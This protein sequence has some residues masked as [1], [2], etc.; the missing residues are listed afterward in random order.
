MKI[1]FFEVAPW[2]VSTLKK[3]F[4]HSLLVKESLNKDNVRAYKNLEVISTFIYSHLNKEVLGEMRL[5]FIATRSTG[6]NHIDTDFCK[7]HNILVSNVPEYGSTTVAEHTFGLILMLTRKLCLAE[8]HARK[9]N[10]DHFKLMGTDLYGKTIGIVGLG[11]IGKCVLKIAQGFG[12]KVVAFTHKRHYV[13]E[14][15]LNYQYLPLE[16]LLGRADIITLHL[17]LTPETYH[18][19]NMNNIKKVK[20]GAI[21]IN[22]ARGDLI[23]TQALIYALENKIVGGVGLDVI[24]GEE[25]I[26]EE[27]E[28]I[29][30]LSLSS[31]NLKKILFNHILLKYPNVVMTP[32]NAFNTKEAVGRI[33]KVTISNID[34][35][36]NKEP[37]N[38]V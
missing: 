23:D 36:L 24:E 8:Q 31:S 7:K 11:K 27:V 20:R 21:I 2:E 14:K 3:N 38:L 35:F 37:I 16:R 22:T 28:I 4:P 19:I 30:H 15:E 10:Y 34:S 6:F 17:P 25:E 1:G 29:S 5:K 9:F 32:H 18:I 33:L 12:M 26:K 13:L